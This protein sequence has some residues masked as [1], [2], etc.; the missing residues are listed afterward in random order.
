MT[1]SP[2]G[3]FLSPLTQVA[4]PMLNRAE[5]EGRRPFDVLLRL[6]T[7]V[8]APASVVM[9]ALALTAPSLIPL[10]L[11]SRWEP[12]VR[13]VQILAIGECIHALSYISYWGFLAQRLSKQLLYYNLVTKPLGVVFVLIGAGFGAEGAAWGY[14]AG[15]ALNWPINLIWLSRSA[16]LPAL[17]FFGNGVRAA[18]RGHR[19]R[20]PL[21]GAR[22]VDRFPIVGRRH[23]W[24]RVFSRRFCPRA[25]RDSSGPS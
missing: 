22:Y 1:A 10:V 6:Q 7:L 19:A 14:V 13:I 21:S 15:L 12:T 17:K 8:A 4:L 25:R 9:I 23:S 2:M 3:S 18:F 11:G 20:C 5:R 24:R 16:G